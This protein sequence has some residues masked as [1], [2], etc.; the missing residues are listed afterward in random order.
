MDGNDRVAQDIGD[1]R[2]KVVRRVHGDGPEDRPQNDRRNPP[3]NDD[4]SIDRS[5]PVEEEDSAEKW[6]NDS[7]LLREQ[8]EGEQDPVREKE[9][10]LP[11]IRYLGG[12]LKQGECEN[13]GEREDREQ[14]VCP[15]RN[16][17]HHM[18]ERRVDG[19]EERTY[20]SHGSR[21]PHREEK[22]E[23]E[24]GD[25]PMLHDVAQ[26]ERQGIG[27]IE[28]GVEHEGERVDGS[29]VDVAAVEPRNAPGT[30]EERSTDVG[31]PGQ[32][33]LVLG[34]EQGVVVS[35]EAESQCGCVE[36]RP[37]ESN[38]QRP[39]PR[40][41]EPRWAVRFRR[42]A[43]WHTE[44]SPHLEPEL[45]IDPGRLAHCTR[46]ESQERLSR[47][48]CSHNGNVPSSFENEKGTK[49]R[50]SIRSRTSA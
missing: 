40:S 26:M 14:G 29:V 34:D 32:E 10:P 15:A 9:H 18:D 23:D 28:L 21:V 25:D 19:K 11:S 48:A 37:D 41:I 36:Q 22:R 33:L 1:Q 3:G 2:R 42:A 39:H 27:A 46:T 31:E 50:E 43:L 20:R 6:Q 49:L 47:S 4:P 45:M 7:R 17:R 38:D 12:A 24:S 44:R 5:R 30:L 16:P 8:G 35:D 13:R